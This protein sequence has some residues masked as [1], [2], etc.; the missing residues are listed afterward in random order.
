MKRNKIKRS[1]NYKNKTKMRNVDDNKKEKK[2]FFS[3]ML[4]AVPI[5]QCSTV[6]IPN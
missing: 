3:S 4:V 1:E 5:K 6:A 2:R